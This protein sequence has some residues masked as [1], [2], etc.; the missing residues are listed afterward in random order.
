MTKEKEDKKT[1][2]SELVQTHDV[3]IA[4]FEPI[5]KQGYENQR[6]RRGIN[7]T[8]KE[9]KAH[10]NEDRHPYAIALTAAKFNRHLAEQ[11]A[12]RTQWKAGGRG[13]EDELQAE[14]DTQAFK[15]VE[16]INKFKY[17][18]S[19]IYED[20]L[21]KKYGA[22]LIEQDYGKN[23]Q[24]DVCLKRWYFD[25]VLWD[26]NSRAYD[27]NEDASFIDRFEW[28]TRDQVMQMYPEKK[29][30]LK[31]ARSQ[32]ETDNTTRR[33][34]VNYLRRDKGKDLL[35][36]I[37]R[38]Q[39]EYKK[40]WKVIP[41]TAEGETKEFDTLKEA[42]GYVNGIAQLAMNIDPTLA[43][44]E[45]LTMAAG[46]KKNF[47]IKDIVQTQIKEICWTGF[48]ILEE[49]IIDWTDKYTIIPFFALNDDGYY[50]N[51]ID[52]VKDPQRGFDRLFSM[53][54]KSMA[55]NIKGNNYQIIQ[56]MVDPVVIANLDYHI[57]KMVEGGHILP[58]NKENAI[59]PIGTQTNINLEVTM[60]EMLKSLIED[61]F[62]GN[63]FQGLDSKRKQTATEASLQEKAARLGTF[64]FIDNLMRWKNLV[65]EV[66][67]D[68]ILNT[69]TYEMKLAISGEALS[70]K[71]QQTLT[72][73]DI[74]K[75]SDN[76]DNQGYLTYNKGG[77]RLRQN[78]MNVMVNEVEM[79]DTMRVLQYEQLKEFSAD[80]VSVGGQPVPPE[81]LLKVS[82]IDPTLKAGLQ[83]YYDL[84]MDML[85]EQAEQQAKMEEA[86][87][88]AGAL[89]AMD[90]AINPQEKENGTN[91]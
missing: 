36:V 57:K 45:Q 88:I 35:K 89:P 54:D 78:K 82:N 50:F 49:K 73:A 28:Y 81:L 26:V 17:T 30:T 8:D 43:T 74:Y 62:G 3:A 41:L 42:E 66:V 63:T 60:V 58:V 52:I 91:E 69:Y 6:Y 12:N 37:W 71:M 31:T 48:D 9:K 47:R 5:W 4:E 21:G 2:I 44:A 40:I 32:I 33:K 77:Q 86:K 75:M 85:K 79:S 59:T 16:D 38:Q 61:L 24:G 53:I 1:L 27:L 84:Q 56:G 14:L 34:L 29:E 87:I 18:E 90:K 83:K 23:P 25:Q 15:Y 70:K 72:E 19:E 7:W 13:E 51:L 39:K 11:R 64:L 10:K 55:K 22:I 76:Y 68:C 67:Y 65:G 20:G 46:I 80:M